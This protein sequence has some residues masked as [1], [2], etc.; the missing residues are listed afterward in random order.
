M[1]ED[2]LQIPIRSNIKLPA[3]LRKPTAPGRYPA[4]V[5]VPG[6]GMTL[7]EWNN[8]FDEISGKLVSQRFLTLQFS[9]DIF[10]SDGTCREL[11]LNQR[12]RQLEDVLQWL[13]KRPDVDLTRVGILAQSYGVP[14]T[15][16]ANTKGIKTY[17]FVSGTFLPKD[18]ITKVYQERGCVINYDGDTTLPRSSGEN[19]TVSKEFWE[20]ID[21]FDYR[22]VA[23]KLIKPV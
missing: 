4:V 7:H 23:K 12:A 16:V 22:Q 2:K 21:M 20:S 1:I 5:L 14:T 3:L 15:L 18:S 11:P 19:T 17:L 9:F 10:K 6:L 8:S 13:F